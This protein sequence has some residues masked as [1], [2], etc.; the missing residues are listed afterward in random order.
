MNLFYF[1]E[2][3]SSSLT[4]LL[5]DFGFKKFSTSFEIIFATA[6]DATLL[7]DSIIGADNIPLE[8]EKNVCTVA[9][10]AL[11]NSLEKKLS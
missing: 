6:L 11:L 10:Q 1:D 5:S 7:I 2:C 8:P 9:A 4:S 3:F